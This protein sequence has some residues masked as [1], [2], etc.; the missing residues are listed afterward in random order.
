MSDIVGKPKLTGEQRFYI[1]KRLG[2][3]ISQNTIAKEL[4]VSA[5]TIS[6]EINRNTLDNFHGVYCWKV[7]DN[8]AKARRAN[9]KV[10]QA[11]RHRGFMSVFLT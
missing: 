5:S 11:F 3:S 10:E 1:E 7:A 2:E 6:R 8:I 9:A 4:N